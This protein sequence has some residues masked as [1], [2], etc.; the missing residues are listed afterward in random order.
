M[1][2]TQDIKTSSLTS[3]Q[4]AWATLQAHAQN[5]TPL[6]PAAYRLAFADPEFLLRPETRGVRFQLELL[7][8]DLDLSAAGVHSTVV[9]YGSARFVAPDEAAQ[10]LASARTSGDAAALAAAELA[11]RNA[12]YYAQ[13]R[14]FA[15]LV[16]TH[17][18]RQRAEDRLFICTGGGPGIME[19]ANRGAHDVG[20]P[21]VGLNIALPHE[22]H[23]NAYVTPYLAFKFHYFALRK[24]HFMMRAKALVVFPGG[25]G[26]LDELF[27]VLTLVQTRKARPVPIVLCGSSYWSRL[28]NLD[29]L[30]EEGAIAPEDLQ[31]YRVVDTPAQAW[32]AIQSFYRL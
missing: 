9:V 2:T 28:L 11:V 19:A 17:S 4:D 10:Q 14:E 3:I 7:K 5:G 13:A 30:V 8:P 22:Q 20:M 16:A 21:S 31:L 1:E 27:E 15:R 32:D 26:T 23:T 6:E 18:E 24:M 29:M 25:F 12:V